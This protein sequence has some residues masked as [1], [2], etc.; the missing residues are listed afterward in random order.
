MLAMRCSL[1]TLNPR[2]GPLNLFAKQC[3]LVEVEVAAK[4]EVVVEVDVEVVV[5]VLVAVGDTH[6][7][8]EY[9]PP[10][11]PNPTIV[12]EPNASPYLH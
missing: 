10:P 2:I 11:V 6:K 1:F 4:V 7:S 9:E 5:A 8:S 3:T 12:S